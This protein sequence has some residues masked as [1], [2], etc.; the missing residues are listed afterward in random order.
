MHD[1]KA[2]NY[3]QVKLLE[4]KIISFKQG[5]IKLS[6]FI[7]DLEAIFYCLK[8]PPKSVRKD[9]VHWWSNL[10]SV[11]ANMA[12]EERSFLDQDDIRILNEAV[13]NLER[14]TK[15]YKKATFTEDEIFKFE[16]ID[17]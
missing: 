16:Y 12:Y 5:K 7:N 4:N 11:Y 13:E 9:F 10:E 17:T 2:Y 14:I 3:R 8:N 6:N 15:D 1:E